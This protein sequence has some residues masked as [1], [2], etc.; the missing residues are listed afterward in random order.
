MAHV[1]CSR[2]KEQARF[3]VVDRESSFCHLLLIAD[4]VDTLMYAPRGDI[5]MG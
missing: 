4:L 1:S 2:G 3:H 5:C